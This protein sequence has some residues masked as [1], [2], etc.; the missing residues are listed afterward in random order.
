MGQIALSVAKNIP[1]YRLPKQV[2][3]E[4]KAFLKENL[5]ELTGYALASGNRAVAAQGMLL[6]LSPGAFLALYQNISKAE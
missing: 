4:A 3:G 1:A 2:A 5:K 6:R